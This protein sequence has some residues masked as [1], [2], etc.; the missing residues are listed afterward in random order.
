[1]K[2]TITAFTPTS[3]W[4]IMKRVQLMSLFILL[5]CVQVMAQGTR[6]T[7]RVTAQTGEALAGVSITVKGTNTG[8]TTDAEGNYGI[9]VPNANS[10]LVFSYVGYAD[11]E[12]R[13]GTNTSLNIAL[14]S[15]AAATDLSEVVVIGYGTAA[16]RD[17]TG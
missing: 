1:M 4:C 13:V 11:R 12:E 9:V 6:V 16:K 5:M 10:V 8:T 7:G 17:L 14:S 15:A 2:K 3:W